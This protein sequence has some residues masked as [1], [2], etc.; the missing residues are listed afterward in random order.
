MDKCSQEQMVTYLWNYWSHKIGLPIKICRINQNI[1]SNLFGQLF[2]KTVP[3]R[4]EMLKTLLTGKFFQH[5]SKG[6]VNK[7]G[8]FEKFVHKHSTVA[9]DLNG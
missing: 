5:L 3:F 6:H 2:F 9:T 4:L 8:N 7:I 1:G